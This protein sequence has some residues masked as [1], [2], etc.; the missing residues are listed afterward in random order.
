[1][2]TSNSNLGSG[3]HQKK[4][5]YCGIEFFGRNN[6]KFCCLNHKAIFNNEKRT[7]ANYKFEPWFSEMKASYRALSL[8]INKVDK[9]SWTQLS[10]LTKLGFDPDCAHKKGMAKNDSEYSQLF[11][12]IYR[13]SD[14]K[15]FVQLFKSETNG[16]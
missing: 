16:I 10:K 13:L 14:D 11:D 7:K 5:Q 4:C 3:P 6:Q 12:I 15:Q 1:M 2:E 8:S 9:N